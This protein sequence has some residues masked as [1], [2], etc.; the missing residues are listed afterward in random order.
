MKRSRDFRT[1][2]DGTYGP[3]WERV[4]GLPCFWLRVD[5]VHV[6]GLGST[7][8]HTAHHQVPVSRGGCDA[9][10]LLPCCGAVHDR[11]HGLGRARG[12][13]GVRAEVAAQVLKALG[14][15]IA[16]LALAYSSGEEHG[17]DLAF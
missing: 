6:C 7:G 11:L 8:G 1:I 15:T 3:V 5:P 12:P 13:D 2:H 16:E 9:G 17:E 10:G 14:V 4:R